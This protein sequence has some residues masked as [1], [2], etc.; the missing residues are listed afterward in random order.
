VNSWCKGQAESDHGDVGVSIYFSDGTRIHIDLT[1]QPSCQVS[2]LRDEDGT[3]KILNNY[4]R[5][6]LMPSPE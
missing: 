1:P 5:T 6:L 4:P 3:D 2:I